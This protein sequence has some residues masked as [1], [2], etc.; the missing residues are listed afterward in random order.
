[1]ETEIETAD[2]IPSNI[3]L[4]ASPTNLSPKLETVSTLQP[5]TVPT[6]IVY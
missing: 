3:R 1:M 6:A 5:N 2:T 4:Q